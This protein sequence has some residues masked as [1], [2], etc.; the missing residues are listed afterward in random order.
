MGK[1]VTS[2]VKGKQV[3]VKADRDLF[4]RLILL[5]KVRNTNI[6][7]CL[8]PY[9]FLSQL[10]L[11]V[12]T[13]TPSLHWYTTSNHFLR[14]L[15]WLKK[16]K[17]GSIWIIDGMAML[18]Q[19][20]ASDRPKTFG[21][22]SE[23]LLKKLIS[24]AKRTKSNQTHFVT[25]RYPAIS[26]KNT[27]RNRGAS[28]GTQVINISGVRQQLPIHWKKFLGVG[29]NKENVIEFLFTTWKEQSPSIFKDVKVFLTHKDQCHAF[30]RRRVK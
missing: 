10:R 15:Q 13:K 7:Y 9:L 12:C 1:E 14:N 22:F 4:A 24:L 8:R 11:V 30:F 23:W 28:I 17:D 21:A 27:E 2:K 16:I 3:T 20:R 6:S 26:I 5:R 25:D 29:V 19:L 18:Q